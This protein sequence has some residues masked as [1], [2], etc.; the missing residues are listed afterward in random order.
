MMLKE[1]ARTRRALG[2][3]PLLFIVCRSPVSAVLAS[4]TSDMR[5][6]VESQTL[7]ADAAEVVNRN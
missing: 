7:S 5:R 3:A 4:E 2:A 6:G 1:N